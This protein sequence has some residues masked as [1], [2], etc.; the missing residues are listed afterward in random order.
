M[1]ELPPRGH[2]LG[3]GAL[4]GRHN[5]VHRASHG[6]SRPDSGHVP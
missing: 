6:G 3:D 4:W 1:A 2:F 5:S